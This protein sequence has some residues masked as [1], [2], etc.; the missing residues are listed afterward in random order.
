GVLI[1]DAL[2]DSDRAKWNFGTVLWPRGGGIRH[3][4]AAL[5]HLHAYIEF[6]RALRQ[7]FVDF[8]EQVILRLGRGV[9]LKVLCSFEWSDAKSPMTAHTAFVREPKRCDGEVRLT[10]ETRRKRFGDFLESL[11]FGVSSKEV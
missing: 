5:G 11:R 2:R 10:C 1:I 4:V 8:L 7:A 3:V 9:V 6:N